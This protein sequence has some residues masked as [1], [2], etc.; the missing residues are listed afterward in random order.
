MNY[1]LPP[2]LRTKLDLIDRI[3]HLER[4]L[5]DRRFIGSQMSNVMFNLGQKTDNPDAPL[6]DSLRRQW[7]K[8]E[9]IPKAKIAPI[10]KPR[11]RNNATTET[12]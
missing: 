2:V 5:E 3:L 8:I 10:S 12:R 7:D 11:P 4:E 1:H 6:F 9:H